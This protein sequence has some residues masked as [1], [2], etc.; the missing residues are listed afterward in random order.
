MARRSKTRETPPGEPPRTIMKILER[1]QAD[2]IGCLPGSPRAVIEIPIGP[3]DIDKKARLPVLAR[4]QLRRKLR[5]HPR[6]KRH[7]ERLDAIGRMS[8]PE[9]L[10][11]ARKLGINAKALVEHATER[12][13]GMESVLEEG[14]LERWRHSKQFP[15]FTGHYPLEIT[16]ELCGERVL[17]PARVE[18]TCTPEWEYFDTRKQAPYVGW[19]ATIMSLHVLTVPEECDDDEEPE[20]VEVSDIFQTAVLPSEIIDGLRD[21]IEE[22]CRQQDAERRQAAKS[23]SIIDTAL[24]EGR[25][26]T[27][28][29]V[30]AELFRLFR[31]KSGRDPEPGE[32]LFFDPDQDQPTQWP[33]AK[34]TAGILEAM[35]KAGTPP[36]IIYA[37]RK[38]GLLLAEGIT[39]PDAPEWK[40]WARRSTSIS[41]WSGRRRVASASQRF[42]IPDRDAGHSYD[43]GLLRFAASSSRSRRAS[44]CSSTPAR[45]L[46]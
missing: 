22:Q 28:S 36:Q 11:L 40:E 43:T 27:V 12:G 18:Y 29:E 6:I 19:P 33:E 31:E 26:P 9:L 1:M 20:W 21:A 25:I 39:P 41:R 5:T 14:E 8:K 10:G 45:P 34:A 32:P 35:R 15:A 3:E 13:K 24:A 42:S 16:F 30:H 2:L 46:S 37:Y 23:E 4:D 38:T 7:V 17:R 44:R